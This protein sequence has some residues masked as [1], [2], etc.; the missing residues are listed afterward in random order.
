MTRQLRYLCLLAGWLAL[1][2]LPMMAGE[3]Y[4]QHYHVY[5]SLT[6]LMVIGMARTLYPMAHWADYLGV[7]AMLQ[8]IHA[9]GDFVS[10]ADESVYAW[11]QASLNGVELAFLGIGGVSE[12][13]NGRFDAS[14]NSRP[15]SDIDAGNSQG[16]RHA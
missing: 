6:S 16:N 4:D 5:Q 9:I 11:I 7:A 2:T 14:G 1:F 13:L 15:R 3:W 8:I 10:P 12:W